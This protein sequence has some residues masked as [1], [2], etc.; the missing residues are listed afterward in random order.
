MFSNPLEEGVVPVIVYAYRLRYSSR[1]AWELPLVVGGCETMDVPLLAESYPEHP[2]TYF[3][4][5]RH[6]GRPPLL[7]VSVTPDSE[8]AKASRIA[9]S[10]SF[11][12]A[13]MP[14]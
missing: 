5:G 9:F 1:G 10:L 2:I 7:G 12:S 13:K 3:P 14:F 6:G 11:L 8:E 4:G